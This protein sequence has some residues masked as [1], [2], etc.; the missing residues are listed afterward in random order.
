MT[1]PLHAVVESTQQTDDWKQEKITFDA[2]Y[3][4]ER[5]DARQSVRRAEGLRNDQQIC[6]VIK[7][8]FEV[9]D[10]RPTEIYRVSSVV[11]I[12]REALFQTSKIHNYTPFISSEI[13]T[14]KPR[15]N[16][17]S[18]GRQTFF[19]PLSISEMWPRS[20]PN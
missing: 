1:R 17:S 3:G 16:T 7:P 6:L 18:I 10:L 19:F 13:V 4:N 8:V 9:I 20:I 11:R 2:A 12:Q 14:R 5:I 15:D